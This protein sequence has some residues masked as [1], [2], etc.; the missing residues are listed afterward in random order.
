[1]SILGKIFSSGANELVKSVGGVLDNL[2]TSK[3]EKLAAELKIKELISSYEKDME[4]NVTDRWISDNQSDSWI[5]RSIRPYS[6]AF[7]FIC[8]IVMVFI[9]SGSIDFNVDDEWKSLLQIVLIT[10]VGAF[11]GGRTFE[12]IK[13]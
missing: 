1:M 6:L 13:K 5:S 12:K 7:V 4:R 3:D 10:M 2:T 8:T 9:D 11:F